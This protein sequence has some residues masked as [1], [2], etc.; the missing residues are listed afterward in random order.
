MA[1]ESEIY[2]KIEE[3]SKT[4]IG[5]CSVLYIKPGAKILKH[6]HK[7]GIEIEYVYK[8]NCKTHKEGE[9]KIWGKNQP[10]EV[11]NNSDEELILICLKVPP[12]SDED[13]NYV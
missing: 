2:N 12:H 8:G 3:I 11:I 13:M 6:Y 4:D 7:K 1:K 9:V 5:S 10:H